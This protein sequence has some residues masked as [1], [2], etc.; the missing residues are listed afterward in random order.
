ML[1]EGSWSAACRRRFC[2]MPGMDADPLIDITPQVWR[3]FQ[4]MNGMLKKSS[5]PA[6][7]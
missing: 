3:L 1:I 4:A 2:S 7:D 6:K 5:N